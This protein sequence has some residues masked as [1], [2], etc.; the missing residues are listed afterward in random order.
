M[1][2][3]LRELSLNR[4]I[5][6]IERDVALSAAADAH[7]RELVVAAIEASGGA[8]TT[9][10]LRESLGVSRKRAIQYLEYLDSVRFTRLDKDEGLRFLR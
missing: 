9:S 10:V 3:A 1:T 5:V 2:R 6:K 7:A 8:T 4:S